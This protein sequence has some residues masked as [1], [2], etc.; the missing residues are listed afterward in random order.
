MELHY[1]LAKTLGNSVQKSATFLLEKITVSSLQ[2]CNLESETDE[3][4]ALPSVLLPQG[5]F[6]LMQIHEN[7]HVWS[8]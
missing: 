7:L 5:V 3:L 1:W 4:S 2:C 6:F 8:I